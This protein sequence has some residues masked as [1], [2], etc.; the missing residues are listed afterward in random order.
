MKAEEILR[1]RNQ[2]EE[3]KVQF[4]ERISDK[5]DSGCELVAFSNTHGGLLVVGINDKSGEINPL[6]YQE[7][8]ETTSLL[9]NMASENVVPS[10]L[11]DIETVAVDGGSI[12]VATVKEGLNKPY[13]DNKG[14]VWVKNG[15][16][17]RKVFDNAELA[18]MMSQ[19]GNFAPD[20]ASVSDIGIKDLDEQV[21]KKYLLNRFSV[22]M[23]NRG[24][25]ELNLRD[26]TLEEMAHFVVKGLG[27]EGL[28]RNLRFI[29]P[30]GKLTVAAVL[31]FAKYPQR[32]LPAYTAKCISYIGNSVGGTTFRD[33]VKDSDMEGGLLHQFETIMAFLT[34]N[35]RNV[36]VEKEFNSLGKLEI[37]YTAL[38]EF[39]VNALVHRSLNWK[40]PIRIFVFDDRVEIHSP[41]ELPNG[42]TVDDIIKG[43]S[44][45]RNLFLFTNANFLLPYTGAGSG[46]IRALEDR[47]DVMFENRVGSHEFVIIVKK[48]SNQ[49]SSK[50]SNQESNQEKSHK[51]PIDKEQND[52]V[53]FCTIPRSSKEIMDMIG[54]SN[55]SVNR[56]KYILSLVEMGLLE[57][58]NPDNPNDRNQKYRKSNRESNQEGNQESNQESN[59]EKLHNHLITKKQKDI[60]NFCSVPRSSK[61]ILDRIGVSN[62]S[63]NRRRHI[64][65]LV[66]MGFLEMTN[67]DN[68]NDRNQKY[69]KKRTTIIYK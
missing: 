17:K 29:R 50:K 12:V 67:P 9:G 65:P 59:Q 19:C 27:V 41:G 34:R 52:I 18:E 21:V 28:L 43:T 69:R 3:T 48:K 40:S 64:L 63:A 31:L 60:V 54:V 14:V 33:K 53:S 47:P 66:E 45:P 62:Q 11:L 4:K 7:A 6:S 46:I 36:Q 8:Q 1:L 2:G 30:D 26:Y 39:V 55:Q 15:A 56:R 37:S 23:E 13:H 68:P 24:I 5:Y 25:N 44:M 38:T 58:T 49:N 22:V 51:H 35:L 32:W 20:E 61:E 16:D 10:I 42:L 57:M